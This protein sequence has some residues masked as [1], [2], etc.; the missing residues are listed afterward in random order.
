MPH[1]AWQSLESLEKTYYD[2]CDEKSP[3][4]DSG[5]DATANGAGADPSALSMLYDDTTPSPVTCTQNQT[6]TFSADSA[7]ISAAPHYVG[8]QF[9]QPVEPKCIKVSQVRSRG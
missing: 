4:C 9:K 6:E 5:L 8:Y 1:A 7:A 3:T 2:A